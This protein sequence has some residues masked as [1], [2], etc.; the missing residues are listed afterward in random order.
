LERIA[1]ELGGSLVLAADE[2]QLKK[3]FIRL[4][5]NAYDSKRK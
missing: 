5:P 1:E 4:A 3:S 2:L